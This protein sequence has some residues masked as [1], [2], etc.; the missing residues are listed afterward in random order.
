MS[1]EI[2]TFLQDI[3]CAWR[4]SFKPK[5]TT[6]QIERPAMTQAFDLATFFQITQNHSQ[7]ANDLI[8]RST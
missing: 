7:M 1:S 8:F 5:S 3:I 2:L 4:S 6:W